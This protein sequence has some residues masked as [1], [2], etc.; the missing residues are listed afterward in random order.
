ML[1]HPLKYCVAVSK[2][3]ESLYELA[4]RDFQDV[5]REKGRAEECI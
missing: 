4:R 1:T 3:E 5:V 2:N